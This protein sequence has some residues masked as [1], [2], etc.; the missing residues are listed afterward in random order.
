MGSHCTLGVRL[1][2]GEKSFVQ[3]GVGQRHGEVG[4]SEL[5][6][7]TLRGGSPQGLCLRDG[8]RSDDDPTSVLTNTTST[9]ATVTTTSTST[10][11]AV[12]GGGVLSPEVVQLQPHCALPVVPR[13]GGTALHR[14][15]V[16]WGTTIRANNTD[17]FQPLA[18]RPL[19]P[20]H[21]VIAEG[22]SREAV[23]TL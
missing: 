5:L 19:H 13:D 23:E 22:E 2:E 6:C 1:D 14:C 21:V 15:P 4:V 11:G 9:S 7:P 16:V 3:R 10:F 20:T 8:K 17:V 12:V 18:G